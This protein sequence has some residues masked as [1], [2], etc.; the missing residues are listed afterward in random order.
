MSCLAACYLVSAVAAPR[1]VAGQLLN[2]SNYGAREGLPQTQV[3]AL[4][5]DR[6]G[7]LWVGTYGGLSRYD[8][9]AF[10]TLTAREGL[11]ANRVSDIDETPDGMLV[12]GTVGGGVC[13]VEDVA[14]T[15]CIREADGLA[16][17]AVVDLFV[18]ESGGVWVASET[19]LTEVHD[20]HPVRS[21]READ[22]LPSSSVRSIWSLDGITALTDHGVAELRGNR[23]T[24]G[25]LASTT[26]DLEVVLPLSDGAF[27]AGPSGLVRHRQGAREAVALPDLAGDPPSFKDAALGRDGRA[28]FATWS[29]AL[30][31]GD[32]RVRRLSEANGL[33]SDQVNRVLVDR[34]GVI[35]FGTERGLSKLVQGAFALMAEESGLPEATARALAVDHDGRLWVG[36]RDGAAVRNGEGFTPVAVPAD[37]ADARVY[38]L[39]APPEG[40]MLVGTRGGLVHY[41]LGGVRTY[42]VADG[43]PHPYVTGLVPDDSGVWIGTEGG[44]ARWE[45][46]EVHRVDDQDLRDV[47]V[48]CMERDAKG[49]LWVGLR[50]GGALEWDGRVVRAFGPQE[51]LTGQTVWDIATDSAGR[52]WIAS[53]GDGAFVVDHGVVQQITVRDGLANDFVWSVLPDSKGSVW[54]FSSLGLDR[55]RGGTIEHYGPGNG[56]R[57]V[58]GT[59][60]AALEDRDGLLW[61]G[62]SSGVYR[63]DPS[64]DAE[65]PSPPPIYAEGPSIGGRLFPRMGA[66]LPPRPGVVTMRFAS[67][68]FRDEQA[69]RF[70]YRLAGEPWSEPVAQNAVSLAGLGPGSYEFDVVAVD[71]AG[72]SSGPARVRFTVLPTFWQTTWFLS[73]SALL[74][75]GLLA[76]APVLRAHRLERERARLQDLVD[77]RTGELARSEERIRA[78]LE[79]STNL[80][81][82]H[83]PDHTLTY[84]SPQSWQFLDCGPEEALT[85]WTEFVTDD[86]AN[87]AGL[88]A[89][90][91]AI[92]TGARQPPY[93]LELRGVSG[94]TIRV[95]VNEAPVVVDGRTVSVVGSLTDITEAREAEE[96]RRRLEQQFL[97]AQRMEAVGRLAGGV[98]HDFNNLLTSILG[99]AQLVLEEVGS[100]G[101]MRDDLAEIEKAARRGSLLVS[102]L[103]G[104]SRRQ[105]RQDE[106]MDARDALSEMQGLVGHLT[107]GRIELDMRPGDEPRYV[108]FD[109]TQLGQALANLVLNSV[110]A[111][112][113]GG[114]LTIS[115]TPL[116]LR[117]VLMRA[118]PDVVPAGR[119]VA[120]SVE[121]TGSGM[122]R[123]TLM[124]VFEPFFTTKGPGKGS[125]LGLSMVYGAVRQGGGY[126]TASSEPGEGTTVRILLPPAD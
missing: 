72:S 80:F 53:N 22:G 13:F 31:Y 112:Q 70:R 28:W 42:Q 20:R 83:D 26:R 36:T 106:R 11:S 117:E 8:G 21:F 4:H 90:E 59:A 121:D 125:G 82:A 64:L 123:D 6:R 91:R 124:K 96:E 5:Q 62:S 93:E 118:G 56:L 102:H 49:H 111:M 79:H 9:R 89:T 7:F 120:I 116:E 23:F 108:R 97:Q 60:T 122:D 47:A 113:R 99:H 69:I 43:L 65:D 109:R 18:D 77:E 95:L 34:E 27:F 50:A 105:I 19:G 46:G 81:F 17:D 24:T 75:V 12:V 14:V 73:L 61:F 66:E 32:G 38:T 1:P 110:D 25:L 114:R 39:A 78:I 67:P 52:V 87:A 33:P 3:T 37:I 103:L 41:G 74:G 92:R 40:G 126:V 45:R 51:G 119:Y 29:G 100:A 54:L 98:A 107:A 63:Y 115:V 16:G 35:W 86:P 85:K 94:R 48:S 15:E 44:V 57:D 88:E 84:V 30:V 10:R 55:L 71:P 101:G 58:E 104:F 76:G 2:F 68:T